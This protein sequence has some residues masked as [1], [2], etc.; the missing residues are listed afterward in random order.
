MFEKLT[1]FFTSATAPSVA[2]RYVSAIVGATLLILSTF[3]LMSK[4]QAADL[5]AQLA[6]AGSQI[7]VIVGAIG[8]L[9]TLLAPI[10]ATMTK[11]SSDKAAAVAKEVDK[12]VPVSAPVV[13]KTPEGVPDIVVPP[14]A[15]GS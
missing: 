7:L 15:K 1:A 11:S 3:G 14:T 13:I 6:T 4:E 9:L 12:Q 10:Y 8:G 2:L 5:T